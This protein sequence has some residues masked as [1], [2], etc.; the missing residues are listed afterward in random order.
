MGPVGVGLAVST[1]VGEAVTAGVAVGVVA[2]PAATSSATIAKP[3][4][5]RGL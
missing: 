1:T 2:H 3:Q 5:G 4:R